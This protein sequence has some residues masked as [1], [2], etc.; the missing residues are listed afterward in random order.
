MIKQCLEDETEFAV[1][2]AR[3]EEI[4]PLG[5]LARIDSVINEYDDGRF[6]ILTVGTE[7]IEVTQFYRD[8]AYLQG[9]VKS[10][11][12]LP[13]RAGEDVDAL[14]RTAVEALESF[15]QE[16]G[17]TLDR[18]ALDG[19]P[20]EELSFF[21]AATDIFSLEEKQKLLKLRSTG[22]R[23]RAVTESLKAMTVQRKQREKIRRMLGSE[24]DI[25]H[26]FN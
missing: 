3:G 17:Y 15:A 23:L 22:D 7:R 11:H 24:G 12:D 26:L 8:A 16:A 10:V 1:L 4:E 25:S 2:L 21:L 9:S 13:E 18:S 5:T 6:D 20:Q 14:A 19:L